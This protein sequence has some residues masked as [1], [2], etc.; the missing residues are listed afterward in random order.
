MFETT[1]AHEYFMRQ[2]IVEAEKAV[3]KDEVPV[4]AVIVCEN[5]IIARA[6]N[7]REMLNDPTAHA[8]M[9]AITQA[10]AY[11]QNWRLTRTTIYVTLEPCAMCAGALVQSRVGTLVYGTVDKKAGACSSV[12][13]LVQEPRFN[14]RLEVIPNILANECKCLLQKFFLENCRTK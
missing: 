10:A 5:R 4:G 7:Q 14:H 3:E 1:D 6:H 8:E 2:A 11:L 9:I 13:N 12:M